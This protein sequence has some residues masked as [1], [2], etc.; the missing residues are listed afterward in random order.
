[1]ELPRL[2]EPKRAAN[3][4]DASPSAT[5]PERRCVMRIHPNA[6]RNILAALAVTLISALLMQS[7]DNFWRVT[8]WSQSQ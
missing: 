8:E 3:P 2:R 4:L 5:H 1:M 6:I 7:W